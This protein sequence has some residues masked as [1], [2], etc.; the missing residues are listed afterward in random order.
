MLTVHHLGVSQSERIVWLCEELGIPYELKRY[1][2]V[3]PGRGLGPPEYKALHPLGTAPII[4]DGDVV[5]PETGAI[6]Q[7]IMGRYGD[8]GLA[9]SPADPDF[10]DYLFWFHFTNASMLPAISG[11]PRDDADDS[12]RAQFMRARAERPWAMIETRLGEKQFL[13]GDRFSA[14]DIIMVFNLTT[15]RAFAPKDLSGYPNILAYL[16]RIGARPAYQ[17]AMAKAD[18]QMAPML[19]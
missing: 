8:G 17:R 18:P 4:T 2:R 5:L 7:Y 1:D 11:A 6:M 15:M 13:A 16:Q 14:A 9:P 3:P 19:T 10:A 12:P